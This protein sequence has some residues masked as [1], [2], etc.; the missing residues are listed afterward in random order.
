[1][2]EILRKGLRG[3]HGWSECV[4]E[5]GSQ[6]VVVSCTI[7]RYTYLRSQNKCSVSGGIITSQSP[8]VPNLQE[9]CT[10]PSG[11]IVVAI[12]LFLGSWWGAFNLLVSDIP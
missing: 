10:N 1:M 9:K 7:V 3:M 8:K 2:S 12:C 5:F 11:D 6:E 4:R